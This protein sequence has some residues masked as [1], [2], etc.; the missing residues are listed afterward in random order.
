MLLAGSVTSAAAATVDD[1]TAPETPVIEVLTDSPMEDEPVTLRFTSSDADSGLDGFWYGIGIEAR[2]EFVAA[3]APPGETSTAEIAFTP[4]E[5]G[6]V[7]V[8]VWAQDVAGNLSDRATEFIR[9]ERVPPPLPEAVL[10]AHWNL[11]ADDIQDRVGE[12]DL[13]LFGVEGVDYSWIE[14]RTCFPEAALDLHG[15]ADGYAAAAT[16]PD[17][18]VIRWRLAMLRRSRCARR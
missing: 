17:L 14:D 1:L 8:H 2:Q 10:T 9:V 4:T 7:L 18:P 13:T 5:F 16:G 11:D 6:L 3:P 12:N 15:S